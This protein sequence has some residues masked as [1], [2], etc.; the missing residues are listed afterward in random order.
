[1]RTRFTQG[2][3]YLISAGGLDKTLLVWKTDFGTEPVEDQAPALSDG[4]SF[5]D[6]DDEPE[7]DDD[8]DS[9][10]GVVRSNEE[11][12]RIH[13]GHKKDQDEEVKDEPAA[14]DNDDMG[15]FEQE[16]VGDGDEFLSV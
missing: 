9:D 1:M 3:N 2:D 6:Q 7:S 13:K 11:R 12:Q 5:E 15:F 14:D 8:D 4:D 10:F 16:D